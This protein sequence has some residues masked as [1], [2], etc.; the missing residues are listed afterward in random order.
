MLDE[1]GEPVR[2]P[3]KL[4]GVKAIGWYIEEYG[5][6]QVSMNITDVKQSPIH[7]VFEANLE[8]SFHMSHAQS[9]MQSCCMCPVVIIE[10][11]KI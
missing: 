3:G 7:K 11:S 5:L 10:S 8:N 1:S 9:S 2:I 4:K 6:A